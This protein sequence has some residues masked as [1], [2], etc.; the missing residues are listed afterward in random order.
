MSAHCA[1]LGRRTVCFGEA[2]VDS[3]LEILNGE[4]HVFYK[5]W[6]KSMASMLTFLDREMRL[7]PAFGTLNDQEEQ[8]GNCQMTRT[9]DFCAAQVADSS[10]RCPRCLNPAIGPSPSTEAYVDLSKGQSPAA[11][12]SLSKHQQSV[13]AADRPRIP[14]APAPASAFPFSN[15]HE[16]VVT[17][18]GHRGRSITYLAASV[19]ALAT[20]AVAAWVAVWLVD[21]GSNSTGANANSAGS[22]PSDASLTPSPPPVE[23]SLGSTTPRVK[24]LSPR[25]REV[26]N[27]QCWDGTAAAALIAC[28]QPEGRDG[29]VW[30]FPS[31]KFQSCSKGSPGPSVIQRWACADTLSISGTPV[32]V[33]YTQWRSETTAQAA[34]LVATWH[35]DRA[36]Q[37]RR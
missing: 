27:V 22:E 31:M 4:G 11:G 24:R 29:M 26:P 35:T 37:S 30:V 25:E 8:I 6:P 17:P 1:G 3:S 32:R 13:P 10:D 23:S 5:M 15:F 36:A 7:P 21:S 28:R 12:V 14:E 2:S 20:C 33:E 18:V 19:A 34:M 9:C 16:P